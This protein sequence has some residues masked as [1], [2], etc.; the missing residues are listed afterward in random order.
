MRVKK[1]TN[2]ILSSNSYVIFKQEERHAWLV[3]PGDS[4]QILDWLKENN[5]TVKGI[6]LTHYH[7]DH[8]YGV[9]DIYEKFPEL[10]IYANELSLAGLSSAKLNGSYYMEM[11]Y[12]VGCKEIKIVTADSQI[13]LFNDE[14]KVRVLFTPGHNNDCISF[15]IGNFLFTGD[16]LIPGVKTH[17]KSKNS[18][19]LI[20]QETIK[21]I[22][23]QYDSRTIICPGHRAMTPLGEIQISEIFKPKH[24][25]KG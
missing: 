17:T 20:A 24:F 25:T 22:F 14:Q 9:N 19:K 5:K 21:G 4:R 18:N 8:I 10:K 16:A 6:L 23:N 3:D 13:E 11:S 15:E 12:V 1:F 7:I 2:S